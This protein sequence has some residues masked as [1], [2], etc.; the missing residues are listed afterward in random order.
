[1]IEAPTLLIWGTNDVALGVETTKGTEEWVP[2]LRIEYLH[3]ASHWVQQ[4]RPAE[5]NRLMLD[6]LSGLPAGTGGDAA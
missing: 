6:F 3:G 5:V 2:N 1:V 4:E